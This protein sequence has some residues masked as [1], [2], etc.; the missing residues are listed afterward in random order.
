MFLS[1]EQNYFKILKSRKPGFFPP[2]GGIIGLR[3][4]L[5]HPTLS[6]EEDRRPDGGE[7]IVKL[8]ATFV[9]Q[10]FLIYCE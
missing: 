3:H 10:L 8:S 1:F 6:D 4:C 7:S 2:S 9:K 5:S